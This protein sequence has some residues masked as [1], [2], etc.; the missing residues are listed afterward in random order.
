MKNRTL[1]ITCI[2]ILAV[3]AASIFLR[4]RLLKESDNSLVRNPTALTSQPDHSASDELKAAE[5][6]GQTPSFK[7]SRVVPKL[8]WQQAYGCASDCLSDPD[9]FKLNAHV[10][11]SKEEADWLAK[12]GFLN[13]DDEA[14]FSKL[15]ESELQKWVLADDPKATLYAAR[16]LASNGRFDEIAS[17]VTRLVVQEGLISGV[18]AQAEATMAEH[19][20]LAAKLGQEGITPSQSDAKHL[21]EYKQLQTLKNVAASF[22]AQ[23]AM[24]GDYIAQ[25]QLERLFPDGVPNYVLESAQR[26]LRT[27]SEFAAKKNYRP[28][29]TFDPRPKRDRP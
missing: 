21:A 9:T 7:A 26:T 3:V 24:R 29:S 19:D 1:L 6:Q 14:F 25:A 17:Q 20:Q 10:A 11:Y 27:N 23:A 16:H 12:Q 13:K 5:R 2:V 15:T 22:Y 18:Y 4:Q 28:T 8:S